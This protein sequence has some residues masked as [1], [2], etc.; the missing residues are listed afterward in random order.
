LQKH[1]TD[2]C[3]LILYFATWLNLFILIAF[4]WSLSCSQHV[5][6]IISTT[7]RKFYFF[8]SNLYASFFFFGCLVVQASTL[9]TMLNKSG[10]SG[11]HC[12]VPQFREKAFKLSPLRMRWA[13]A[14]IIQ[15]VCWG[16]FYLPN[17]L[18]VLSWESV[19]F[20]K[21]FFP[22]SFG[23]IIWYLFI[24]LMWCITGIDL[25]VL[26]HLCVPGI[27]PTWLWYLILLNVLLNGLLIFCWGNL[28]LYPSGIVVYNY[29]VVSLSDFGIRVMMAS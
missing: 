2:F 6:N 29:L 13:V 25:H 17:L 24:L 22:A 5:I 9:C 21:M 28:H 16:T 3:I 4:G 15:F 8:P 14:F 7:N 12:L 27:N 10:E 23:M 11:H 19:E 18:R 20:C 1:N 26:N